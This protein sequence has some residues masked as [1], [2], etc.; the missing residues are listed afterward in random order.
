MRKPTTIHVLTL[1]A[2][3]AIWG[4]A[5]I[6]IKIGVTSGI[7]P[8]TLAAGRITLAAIVLVLYALM[9]GYA[10]PK[11]LAAWR[12]LLWIGILS[13]ALP[14]Y[15]ISWAEQE[16]SSGVAAILMAMGPL[17]VLVLAHF[18]TKDDRFTIGKI[19]AVVF[20]FAGVMI[21]I[22]TK[23]FGALG[24]EFVSQLAVMGASL[25][26]ATSGILVQRF[27]SM[28]P[29]MITAGALITST[30]IIL[31]LSLIIE[32]P[33]TFSPEPSAFYAVVYLGLFP[34]ALAYLMRF[35]L[36]A[37]VGVTFFSL[38]GYMVPVFGVLWGALILSEI[39]PLTSILGLG[40][41]LIG[42]QLSRRGRRESAQ[43]L[44]ENGKDSRS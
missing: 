34:T 24:I 16:I 7:G 30:V 4:S 28:P 38:V 12:S 35:H 39:I 33:W 22:G 19:L 26:Y 37:S 23:P 32:R 17:Y 8:M 3:A 40:L 20:G 25:C 2:I 15:L 36:I 31:P 21:I 27:K 44:K 10:F 43:S 42:I 1:L 9:R 6:A 29:T 5:F 41:I 14:F 18:L 11:T 13:I